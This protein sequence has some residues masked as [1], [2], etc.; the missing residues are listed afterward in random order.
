[1]AIY[2]SSESAWDVYW[3]IYAY[4][5]LIFFFCVY[6]YLLIYMK[7]RYL[8]TEVRKI[9]KCLFNFPLLLFFTTLIVSFDNIINIAFN[10]DWTHSHLLGNLLF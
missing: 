9:I 3:T 4:H 5:V 10:L 6:N 7:L 1:M 2:T 8:S